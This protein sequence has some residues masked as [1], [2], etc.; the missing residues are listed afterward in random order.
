M[1]G[2]HYSK[3]LCNKSL[4]KASK[5]FLRLSQLNHLLAVGL[6][7]SHFDPLKLIRTPYYRGRDSSLSLSQKVVASFGWVNVCDSALYTV[8]Q[9]ASLTSWRHLIS[10]NRP[11]CNET[12]SFEAESPLQG[13]ESLNVA[14]IRWFN[15]IISTFSMKWYHW[16]KLGGRA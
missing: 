13:K 10:S 9:W 7:V 8:K 4:W 2:V 6:G 15:L 5:G 14:N 11:S 12:A 3:E 1:K 16:T